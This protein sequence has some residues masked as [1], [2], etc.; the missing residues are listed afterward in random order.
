[1]SKTKTTKTPKN[2]RNKSNN[3]DVR[4]NPEYLAS[5]YDEPVGY[6]SPE[7]FVFNGMVMT[8]NY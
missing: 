3:N 8:A 5:L 2:S 4:V 1:M 7:M 6:T